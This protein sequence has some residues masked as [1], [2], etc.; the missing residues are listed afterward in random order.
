MP[1]VCHRRSARKAVCM[2]PDPMRCTG[3]A[4]QAGCAECCNPCSRTGSSRRGRG[5]AST[6]EG[7]RLRGGGRGGRRRR[8]AA[9]GGG[10]GR[11]GGGGGARR[12]RACRGGGRVGTGRRCRWSTH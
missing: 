1:T 6:C 11:G 10:G 7:R 4:A 9:G 2:A 5:D 12:G 8:V 3:R